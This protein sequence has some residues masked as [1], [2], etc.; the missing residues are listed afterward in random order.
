MTIHQA[1]GLEFPVVVV[2]DLVRNV[3]G[4][5]DELAFDPELGPLVRRVRESNVRVRAASI[6]IDFASGKRKPTRR[7]GCCTWP[8][9][10]PRTI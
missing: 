6:C 1:K 9:R 8:R 3:S 10:G 5:K 4:S 2:P 7:F